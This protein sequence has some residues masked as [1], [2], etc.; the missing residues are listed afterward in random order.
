MATLSRVRGS[1]C[2]SGYKTLD[3][4][5]HKEAQRDVVN[6]TAFISSGNEGEHLRHYR[7]QARFG[8]V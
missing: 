1:D 6:K 3:I 5:S 2:L 4:Y 7:S 8:P